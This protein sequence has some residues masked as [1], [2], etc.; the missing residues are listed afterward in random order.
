M[1]WAYQPCTNTVTLVVLAPVV[2]GT[3]SCV[4]PAEEGVNVLGSLVPVPVTPMNAYVPWTQPDSVYEWP[5]WT[6]LVC[7]HWALSELLAAADRACAPEWTG[8]PTTVSSGEQACRFVQ[9]DVVHQHA[10][11]PVRKVRLA[12]A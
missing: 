8:L 4:N 7:V 1:P 5:G 9:L 10:L 2:N 12:L 3:L 11:A 6:A